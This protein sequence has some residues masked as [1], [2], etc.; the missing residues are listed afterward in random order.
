M[1]GN[2]HEFGWWGMGMG[3]LFMLVFWGLVI[4]ALVVLVRFLSGRQ[5]DGAAGGPREKTA[6][7]IVQARYARGEIDRNEYEQKMRDL[8]R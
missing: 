1:M 2:W 6:R 3:W 8:E 7:E 4:A 5:G